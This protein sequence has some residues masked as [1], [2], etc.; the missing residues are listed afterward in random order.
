MKSPR[1]FE[2]R[3]LE[4][5]ERLLTT[6]AHADQP[7]WAQALG[8]V[9][10]TPQAHEAWRGLI[11]AIAAWRDAATITENEPCG[12][13]TPRNDPEHAGY[14]AAHIAAEG[15]KLLA[16]LTRGISAAEIFRNGKH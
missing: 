7:P 16:A 11:S 14:R 6:T 8:P 9:P 3:L 1:V 15:A 13:W 2:P 10:T 12:P 5:G 4:L